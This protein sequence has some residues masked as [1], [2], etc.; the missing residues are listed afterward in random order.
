MYVCMYIY[1]YIYIISVHGPLLGLL[2]LQDGK[3][4]VNDNA[5]SSDVP[6]IPVQLCLLLAQ[7]FRGV[8]ARGFGV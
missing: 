6:S 3:K 8:W 2:M 4:K 5:S 1:I 7:G